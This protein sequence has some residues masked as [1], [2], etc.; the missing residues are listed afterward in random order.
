MVPILTVHRSTNS[1]GGNCVEILFDGRRLI[2]DVGSPLDAEKKAKPETLIPPTLDLKSPVEAVIISHAHQD[3]YGLLP[4]LPK[5][6]PIWCGQAT[7][8][9]MRLTAGLSGVKIGHTLH[10]YEA[11]K[12]FK[13][14][15]FTITPYLTDHSA[16]DAYMLLVEVAG[17]RILYSGDFRRVGRKS[18]LVD[19]M[20]K[21]PPSRI[22]VL[23]MEGTTLGR[24]DLYPTEYDLE[25]RFVSLFEQVTGRVF[26]TW[27]AQN[28]DRTVT[29]YKACMQAGRTLL[30]DLYTLY[31]LDCLSSVRGTLPRLGLPFIKGVVT[32]KMKRLIESSRRLN[33]PVFIKRCACSGRTF[34]AKR[35][36]AIGT[37]V[38]M[39]RPSLMEDFELKGMMPT[40]N[41]TWVFSMWNGYL[42]ESEYIGL[43]RQFD[44]VG[45]AFETIHTSGHAGPT[46]LGCFAKSMAARHL[47]PIHSLTWDQHL[48]S[49]ENVKRLRDGELFSLV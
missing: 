4:A 13:T 26:I 30:L 17:K 20:M 18:V 14:G 11:F 40:H 31:V 5:A 1:I 21:E 6:W 35:L 32:S 19:R 9:L 47:V 3:H 41:D 15:P 37:E 28:I 12:A 43:R 42:A 8:I 44:A 25:Q 24:S 38:I 27:S 36:G 10:N 49:F 23:L 48:G 39:L 22:D 46:D 7:G 16:Y 33:D 29:I 45:A 34:S 2:L